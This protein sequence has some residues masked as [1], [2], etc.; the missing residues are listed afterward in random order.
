MNAQFLCTK[1]LFQKYAEKFKTRIFSNAYKVFL[2][3]HL[4]SC[5][6]VVNPEL[7]SAPPILVIDGLISNSDIAA[8]QV[9]LSKTAPFNSEAPTPLVSGAIVNILIN[10]EEHLLSETVQ[11]VYGATAIEKIGAGN[12]VKLEVVTDGRIYTAEAFMPEKLSMDSVSIER[13][14]E[15]LSF[16]DGYYFTA[17][18]TEIAS[19]A[20]YYMWEIHV[21]NEFVSNEEILLSN[22]QNLNGKRIAYELPFSIALDDISVGDTLTL[23]NYSLSKAAFDYYNGLLDLTVTG[24][25][26]QAIPDNPVSNIRGGALGF[27]NVCQVDTVKAIFVE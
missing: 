4:L 7:V 1:S 5:E 2:C 21:N 9:I 23:Y 20:N 6:E 25:P 26:S 19:E 14:I 18:F 24:S 12:Q 13:R 8:N 22:D 11:G 17:H 15:D 10:E 16:D 3:M 27:F